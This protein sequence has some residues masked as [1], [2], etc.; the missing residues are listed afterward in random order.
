MQK[1][2]QPWGRRA[3]YAY[4]QNLKYTYSGVHFARRCPALDASFSFFI[5]SEIVGHHTP[6]HRDPLA[7]PECPLGPHIDRG[8][9]PPERLDPT[10]PP[11]DDGDGPASEDADSPPGYSRPA[12]D[13]PEEAARP[14]G[15]AEGHTHEGQPR[16]SDEIGVAFARSAMPELI[17][18]WKRAQ[19]HFFD[20]HSLTNAAPTPEIHERQL[21]ARRVQIDGT[22][23]GN[24]ARDVL[25]KLGL[26]FE[27][28]IGPSVMPSTELVDALESA[29]RTLWQII[30]KGAKMKAKWPLKSP[31]DQ[32]EVTDIA[33]MM[34]QALRAVEKGKRSPARPKTAGKRRQ[35]QCALTPSDDGEAVE[36][37]YPAKHHMD[38]EG[39]PRPKRLRLTNCPKMVRSFLNLLSEKAIS[40]EQALTDDAIQLGWKRM[41]GLQ[42]D[43]L[44]KA[45]H[46]GRQKTSNGKKTRRA[47]KKSEAGREDFEHGIEADNAPVNGEYG[48]VVHLD[49]AIALRRS[50]GELRKAIWTVNAWFREQIG[51]P[52]C[53]LIAGLTSH[54]P[55][56]EISDEAR[57]NNAPF[58][59]QALVFRRPPRSER[60]ASGHRI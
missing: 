38:S 56:P 1:P 58:Q 3:Q 16:Q 51:D 44:W 60:R 11:P 59:I 46:A 25:K 47:T 36:V 15:Q 24:S 49:D 2:T 52:D 43:E 48:R 35:T 32:A 53:S 30:T 5:S 39:K 41:P 6:D 34:M 54:N 45:V 40:F 10:R 4:N 33:G 9:W 21:R 14:A 18:V 55:P 20:Q 19:S 26:D 37:T 7:R 57:R 31:K 42:Y 13:G 22:A 29:M 12:S 27:L 17:T 50:T 8:A 23:V 28:A